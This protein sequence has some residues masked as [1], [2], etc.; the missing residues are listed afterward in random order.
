MSALVGIFIHNDQVRYRIIILNTN[1]KSKVQHSFNCNIPL[2]KG[3]L[4]I[5]Y[6]LHQFT[7]GGCDL[8][9]LSLGSGSKSPSVNETLSWN[10]TERDPRRALGCDR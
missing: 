3:H 5:K 2:H 8:D 7:S 9:A 10:Y 4:S 1:H 6:N